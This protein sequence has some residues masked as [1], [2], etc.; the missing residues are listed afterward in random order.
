[1]Q[2]GRQREKVRKGSGSAPDLRLS[3]VIAPQFTFPSNCKFER[4]D[5]LCTHSQRYLEKKYQHFEALLMR[6]A[7]EEWRPREVEPAIIRIRG[8]HC[9]FGMPW[10]P[11]T[12][13]PGYKPHEYRMYHIIAHDTREMA[14]L[15]KP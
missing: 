6:L 3:A 12:D 11:R 4:T 10:F 5:Y 9:V 8:G 13:F 14:F 2:N 1:M 15:C 7:H